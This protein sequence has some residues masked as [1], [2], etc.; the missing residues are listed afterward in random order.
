MIKILTINC[1]PKKDGNTAKLLK[2]FQSEADRIGLEVV[3]INLYEE[4]EDF[5][6][7]KLDQKVKKLT[8]VQALMSKSD[9]FV[10]ATP[11]YWFNTP[12]ILKNFIDNLTPLEENNWMLEGKVGGFIVYE[13]QGGGVEVLKNLAMTFNHMGVAI[14]PYSLIFYRGRQDKWALADIKLLARVMKAEVEAQKKLIDDKV[15]D[16]LPDDNKLR[17]SID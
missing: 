17:E 1:S 7:G 13:P 15:Y 3:P 14:A 6:H 12:A 9:G 10:I 11:T 5:F 2:I 4:K 16:I 8:R